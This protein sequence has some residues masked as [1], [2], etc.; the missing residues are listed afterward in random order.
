LD[1]LNNKYDAIKNLNLVKIPETGKQPE[2]LEVTVP[3]VKLPMPGSSN[4]ILNTKVEQ[5]QFSTENGTVQILSQEEYDAA[6][7]DAIQQV[8]EEMG[9]IP[10]KYKGSPLHGNT[11]VHSPFP[12]ILA[13]D[14][15][16]EFEAKLADA[17]K[18]KHTSVQNAIAAEYGLELDKNGNV[19]D[20]SA[21]DA[22]VFQIANSP[23]NAALF[24]NPSSLNDNQ[25]AE[26]LLKMTSEDVSSL[27]LP[28][29]ILV[30][31]IKY[32][33][34]R[35]NYTAGKEILQLSAM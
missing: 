27:Q 7:Q 24:E 10:E 16:E 23:E 1:D 15:L 30:N 14:K 19:K 11:D 22:I 28:D 4:K 25:R 21:F 12:N 32:E 3:E 26:A 18:G 17:M 31:G 34:G 29:N 35:Y 8:F 33:N 20:K 5:Q 6:K 2:K 9:G 13:D